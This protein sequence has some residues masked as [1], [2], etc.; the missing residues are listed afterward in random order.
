M[1][2]FGKLIGKE[3]DSKDNS[4]FIGESGSKL[5]EE[6][7]DEKWQMPDKPLFGDPGLDNGDQGYD[8]WQ[9]GQN[10]GGGVSFGKQRFNENV[11]VQE[12]DNFPA[13]SRVQPTQNWSD[14][15][16]SKDL[17]IISNKLDAI[18]STLE[19]LDYRVKNLE[20]I[21]EGEQKPQK[22]WYGK[23]F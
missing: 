13:D 19:N 23:N 10:Q 8:G 12:L 2:F 7:N 4:D 22:P 21:A 1:G 20:R 14:K 3:Q 11:Q 6:F 17:E 9:S 15:N 5:N 16:I 18:K